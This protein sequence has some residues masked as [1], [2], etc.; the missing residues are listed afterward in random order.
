MSCHVSLIHLYVCIYVYV[1]IIVNGKL[2][3]RDSMGNHEVLGRGGIQFTSAGSGIRHSEFNGSDKEM[4]HFIQIWVLPSTKGLKPNYQTIHV[5][6]SQK[7]NKLALVI[8]PLGM[9]AATTTVTTANAST[10]T[11]SNEVKQQSNN[12]SN[13]NNKTCASINQDIKMYASILQPGHTITFN[14]PG[15]LVISVY[16]LIFTLLMY[17]YV[18]VYMYLCICDGNGNGE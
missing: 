3:H 4:V 10:S 1:V 7:I 2:S 18:S 16:T 14:L 9:Q 15:M 12:S 13:N 8:A 5:D 17:V 6:D 11:S